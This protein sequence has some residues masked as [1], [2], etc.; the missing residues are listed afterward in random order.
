MRKIRDLYQFLNWGNLHNQWLT[1][2]VLLHCVL[3]QKIVLVTGN[4]H[5]EKLSLCI[6]SLNIMSHNVI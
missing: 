2:Y 4:A 6:F 3:H 5:N 1:T